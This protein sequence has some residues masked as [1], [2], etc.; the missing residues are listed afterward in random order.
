MVDQ[1]LL[2]EEVKKIVSRDDV[3]YVIG[4]KKG[5]Y[6]FAVSPAFAYSSEY[7]DK[8]IFNPLCKKNLAA[9]PILEDKLPLKKGEKEDKRKIGIV[10]KGCDT[11]A[12]VQIIQEKGLKREDIVIIGI[13]CTGV[14]D[15]KKIISRFPSEPTYSEIKEEQGVYKITINGKVHEIAKE[16]LLADYCTSCIAPNP[17]IYDVLIG[18]EVEPWELK[19]HKN[20]DVLK[21]KSVGE[22]WEYWKEHFDRCIRCYACREACPLCYCK[23]CMADLLNPQWIRRSVNLS[24]NTAWNIMRAYHLAGRCV[25]CGECESVCPVNIPLMELN[26][27]IEKDVKNLFEYTAGMDSEEKP[28]FGTFRPDDPEEFIM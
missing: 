21:E 6:G 24:E 3:K 13:P 18:E 7:A 23:E 26:K 8:F 27:E 19:E 22:R 12:L 15:Q 28:L 16:E 20:L 10:A 2:I 1:Q 17:V 14:I 25:G 9:Y 5:T 4:Y 11:R